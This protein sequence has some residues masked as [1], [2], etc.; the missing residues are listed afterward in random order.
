MLRVQRLILG[1][2]DQETAQAISKALAE[3]VKELGIT[4]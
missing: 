4:D 1:N 3:V 2:G